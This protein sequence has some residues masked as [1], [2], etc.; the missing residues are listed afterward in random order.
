MAARFSELFFFLLVAHIFGHTHT[1]TF[2]VLTDKYRNPTGA[3]LLAPS[4]TPLVTHQY[5]KTVGTNPGIRQYLY[6]NNSKSLLDY[7]QYFVDLEKANLVEYIQW[8]LLYN[9]S[10]MYNVSDLTGSSL[11]KVLDTIKE[12]P[13]VFDKA[14]QLNTLL[15][16]NGPC[17][18][19]CSLNF[20]CAM[21]NTQEEDMQRCLDNGGGDFPMKRKT[22]WLGILIYCILALI[23]L[24][25]TTTCF[26]KLGC[27]E[28]CCW[29]RR[30]RDGEYEQLAGDI[31]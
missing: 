18:Y 13:I 7:Q 29:I 31:I 9:F 27:F 16:D 10:Q 20:V 26:Y 6:R 15:H 11:R 12:N 19:Y 14:Y 3:L 30:F 28:D 4:I 22:D 2:R 23:C 5:P 21:G 1:D 25:A 24:A 17:D 8:T